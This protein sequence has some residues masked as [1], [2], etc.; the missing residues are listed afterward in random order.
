MMVVAAAVE[1]YGWIGSGQLERNGWR[2][3]WLVVKAMNPGKT[4]VSRFTIGV[5]FIVGVVL[6]RGAVNREA[7]HPRRAV[8]LFLLP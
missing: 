7:V 8:A 5:R 6:T 4:C 1:L 2:S 3:K